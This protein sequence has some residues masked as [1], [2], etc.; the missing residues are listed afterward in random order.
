MVGRVTPCAP[1]DGHLTCEPLTTLAAGRGLPALPSPQRRQARHICRTRTPTKFQPRRG[2]IFRSLRTAT[3]VAP[4]GALENDGF[5]GYKYASPNGL[6]MD[7][8]VNRVGDEVTRLISIPGIQSEP[9]HVGSYNFR[10]V[11]PRSGGKVSRPLS[12]QMYF[13]RGRKFQK[14]LSPSRVRGILTA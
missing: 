14:L 2:G 4:S 9:P 3:N 12:P 8:V 7:R 6:F 11:R 5:E 13:G 1:S 10:K